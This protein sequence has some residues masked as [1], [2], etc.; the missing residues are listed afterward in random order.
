MNPFVRFLTSSIG[1]KYVMAVTGLSLTGFLLVHM[2]GNLTLYAGKQAFNDYAHVIESNP[3]L[4]RAEAGRAGLF[5]VH[6]LFAVVLTAKNKASRSEGYRASLGMGA[7]TFAS[8]TMWGTGPLLG[9]VLLVHLWD[10]RI[11]KEFIDP[12]EYDLA[13]MVIDRLRQPV[14]TAIYLAGIG[15]VGL[16]LWHG[17]QSSFQTLGLSHPRYRALAMWTGRLISLALVAGFGGIP[18]FIFLTR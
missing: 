13:Q 16:H 12:E 7:K 9:L 2:A 14:G 10:F 18:V 4:P 15:L 11:A 6:L 1:R 5:V 8:Q 17:F 3:L